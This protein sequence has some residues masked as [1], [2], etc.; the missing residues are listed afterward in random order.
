MSTS[1]NKKTN[2]VKNGTI[3]YLGV[4]A[5]C[6]IFYL[7]YDQFSHGIH[8]FFMTW[9]FAFPFVLGAVPC[10]LL[11][12]VKQTPVRLSINLWNSGV[13]AV[14][15]ASLLMGIFE[16]AGAESRY[17]NYL[18]AA[19]AVMLAAGLVVFVVGKVMKK[20]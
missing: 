5:F 15:C 9:L 17:Q 7:V 1:E 4:S 8:S 6:F 12:L 2:S 20:G 3:I 19:G 10:V 18:M 13:S 16:I 14:T 11:W